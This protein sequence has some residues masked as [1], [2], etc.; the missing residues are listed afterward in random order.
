MAMNLML[1]LTTLINKSELKQ[2]SHIS[3]V[4]GESDEDG[5]ISGVILWILSIWIE[6][7][8]PMVPS[9]GEQIAGNVLSHSHSLRQRVTLD[10]ELV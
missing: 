6:V 9:D 2:R 4:A 10:H 7:N 3:A 5:D 1:P 8:R